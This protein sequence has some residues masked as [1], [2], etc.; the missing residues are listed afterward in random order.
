MA[1]FFLGGGRTTQIYKDYLYGTSISFHS[2]CPKKAPETL[3]IS[4]P[5]RASAHARVMSAFCMPL[6][7]TRLLNYLDSRKLLL[8][9]FFPPYCFP[10]FSQLS[11]YVLFLPHVQLF[12]KNSVRVSCLFSEFT[13]LNLYKIQAINHD[14]N[15]GSTFFTFSPVYLFHV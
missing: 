5:S 1:F 11:V 9:N 8:K 14:E 15:Q 10:E 2:F 7:L 6:W 12:L 13:H 3:S 4:L